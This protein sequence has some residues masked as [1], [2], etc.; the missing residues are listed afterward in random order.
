MPPVGCTVN[1]K[2]S[3]ECG[4]LATA[5]EWIPRIIHITAKEGNSVQFLFV[6]KSSSISPIVCSCWFLHSLSILIIKL[7]CRSSARSYTR[8]S[9][10]SACQAWV[11]TAR[12]SFMFSRSFHFWC[13]RQLCFLRFVWVS[14]SRVGVPRKRC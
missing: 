4:E 8:E 9:L 2:L 3:A 5:V 12:Y 6:T 7:I 11:S 14:I 10:C 1:F 13:F